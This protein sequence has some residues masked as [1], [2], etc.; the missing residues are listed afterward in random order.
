LR[1]SRHW[2]AKRA[3]RTSGACSLPLP[4]L[5]VYHTDVSGEYSNMTEK[6]PHFVRGRIG[7]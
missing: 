2:L 6:G 4:V 5:A 1:G 7:G 3:S